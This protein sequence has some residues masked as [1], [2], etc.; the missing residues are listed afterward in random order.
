[1]QHTI[2]S[3]NGREIHFSINPALAGFD[4]ALRRNQPSAIE[5]A[6]GLDERTIFLAR[7]QAIVARTRLLWD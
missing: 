2:P 3:A 1:M 5:P 4:R 6:A 7:A